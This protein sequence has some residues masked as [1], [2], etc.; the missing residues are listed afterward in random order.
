MRAAVR[1]VIDWYESS[2][3]TLALWVRAA[4]QALLGDM[5]LLAAGTTL[6]GILAAVPTLAAAV[7]L[8]SLVA[9]ASQIHGHLQSLATVLPP[10]VA[11]FLGEQLQRQ[12]ARSQ[13][14][15]G[16]AIFASALL[17]LWSARSATRGIMDTLNRAYRVRER[18]GPL[19]RFGI[20][21][22]ITTAVLVG[23]MLFFAGVVVLPTLIAITNLQS[24]EIVA[25]LRWPV[26][27]VVVFFAMMLLYRFAPSPRPLGTELHLWPGALI[28]TALLFAVSLGLSFWV[29]RVSDYNVFY[30]TFGSVVVTIL[31]F[32][33]TTIAVVLGGFANA[34]LE[35]RD[36]APQPDF[37]G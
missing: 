18:R 19:V 34:E 3:S 28:A 27:F 22:A 25:Y 21:M 9:D 31:W 36:G 35:R 32:Y 7:G 4:N 13:G 23:I 6:Y 2:P 26:L 17:A 1:K 12:A 16:V 37:G 11:D 20:T 24:L 29:E 30:G 33:F 5:Q 15:L 8:Y 10:A 14:E